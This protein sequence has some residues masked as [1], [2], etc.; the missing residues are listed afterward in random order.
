LFVVDVAVDVEVP[1]DRGRALE[2]SD[3]RVE[4][5]DAVVR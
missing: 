1:R 3:L 5:I 4:V 2:R